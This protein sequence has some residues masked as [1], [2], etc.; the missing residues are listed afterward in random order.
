MVRW[1]AAVAIFGVG[2]VVAFFLALAGALENID[3]TGEVEPTWM[4]AAVTSATLGLIAAVWIIR[5]A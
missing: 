3:T 4:L 1:I 2:L 5:R